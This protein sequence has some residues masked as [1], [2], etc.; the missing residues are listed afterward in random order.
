VSDATS[1]AV[2]AGWYPDRNEANL[3]RWWDGQ[4]WTD[5]TQSTAPAAEAF[6]Q[7]VSVSAFGL[8]EQAPVAQEPSAAHYVTQQPG[9]AQYV[10]QQSAAAQYAAAPY[11]AAAPVIAPGWYPDNADPGLQRWWDGAQ[12]TT[13]TAPSAPGNP[14]AAVAAGSSSKNAL[15][16]LALVM[17]IGS[18]AGLLVA[19]FLLLAIPGIIL[20]IVA[21]RR[22]RRFEPR[23][24]RRG[25]AISA[26]VVGAIGLVLSVLLFVAAILVY[27]Q[28]HSTGVQTNAQPSPPSSGAIT[29][30]STVDELKQKIAAS[31]SR[32]ASVQVTSV[33]CDAAASMVPGSAFDCGAE[34]ADGR[35]TPVRVNITNPSGSGVGFG[36]GH[37]PLLAAGAAPSTHQY[38]VEDIS[39]ELTVNLPGAWESPVSTVTCDPSASLTPGST[40]GCL[41]RLTDGRSG[42]LL[43]TITQT[44]GYDVTVL[45]LPAGSGSASGGSGGSDGSGGSNGS[46]D[47]DPDQLNS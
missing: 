4:Q 10:V 16:T 6:V 40:F 31:V 26:I 8:Q 27:Q 24:A 43:I 42:R 1:L 11:E 17:S 44:S 12:W 36:L 23:A 15:A 32:D 30:P 13:H 33:T 35:W 45:Q 25:Q 38:T 18:F 20:G 41:V 29:F 34:A 47:T 28:V 14:Y 39:Y 22:A 21:L 37:G 5:H 2:P 46:G 3:V 9:A 7:P 19:W